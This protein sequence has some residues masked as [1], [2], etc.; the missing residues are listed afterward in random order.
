MEKK[1]KSKK[2]TASK[3]NGSSKSAASN[4][5][6][7]EMPMLE[8]F[9][10]DSL[11]D[12]YWAEK[13]LLKALPKL[14]KAATSPELKKVFQDHVQ[15][16]NEQVAR[17]EKVFEMMGKKAQGKKCD[18][19]EGLV[20]EAESIIEDTQAGTKTRDVALIMAAQ[21]VEHYEIATYGGLVTIAKTMGKNDIAD[22]LGQT[23]TEEKQADQMLTDVAE[24][25][26][27]A[28]A[29]SEQGEKEPAEQKN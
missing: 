13:H 15:V 26:I 10:L 16:T 23:L 4:G 28:Q 6:D 22:I 12:I 3:S 1:A 7:Q 25:N 21:K 29:T 19:M 27:N 5:Q 17:L 2:A 24:N 14:N 8:K 18:A 11:K 20:K 9:T